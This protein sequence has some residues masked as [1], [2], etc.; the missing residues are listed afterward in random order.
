MKD[1]E[2]ITCHDNS[3]GA[4]SAGDV[5][6]RLLGSIHRMCESVTRRNDE[7]LQTSE[8]TEK[9]ERGNTLLAGDHQRKVC[10]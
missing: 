10:V 7:G 1:T 3:F 8:V 9:D 2:A 6:F 4:Q 5:G